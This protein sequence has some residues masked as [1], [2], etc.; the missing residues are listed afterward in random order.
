MYLSDAERAL[1]A[2]ELSQKY[3][4]DR[5]TAYRAKNRGWFFNLYHDKET[6]VDSRFSRSH[7]DDILESSRRGARLAIKKI[8]HQT[9]WDGDNT[10]FL[11]PITEDDLIGE[12]TLRL[13]EL[14][15]HA[16]F[17]SDDWR[18]E[19][20]R[21]TALSY[22]KHNVIGYNKRFKRYGS[23]DENFGVS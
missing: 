21:R 11:Y 12:C 22:I 20:A 14:S 17:Q 4:I 16:D 6:I 15:G 1:R 9:R 23:A 3:G 7:I 10:S 2:E 19:V 8:R 13:L 18:I 5:S